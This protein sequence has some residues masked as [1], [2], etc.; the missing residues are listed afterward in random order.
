MT[1]RRSATLRMTFTEVAIFRCAIFA[2]GRRWTALP[3][4]FNPFGR[5]LSS[6]MSGRDMFDFEVCRHSPWTKFTAYAARL[7]ASPRRFDE[8]D[9]RRIDPDVTSLERVG[10]ARRL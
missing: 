2:S 5:P 1:T 8:Y 4:I 7:E 9:L 3:P 6:R 10:D